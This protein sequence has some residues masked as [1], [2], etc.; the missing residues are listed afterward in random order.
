MQIDIVGGGL[1]GLSTAISLKNLHKTIEVN[2]FEK[3]EKIGY[4]P[5]GR[6]CGE[7]YTYN[8]EWKYW[9]PVGKSYYND[10]YNFQIILSNKSY[11]LKRKPG[12]SY[13]L[14]RQEF[15]LQN[16]KKAKELGVNFFTNQKIKSID[17]LDGDYIIDA[18]GCPSI[19]KR[20]LKI[21]HQILGRSY[22][23]TLENSNCFVG[24][25]VKIFVKNSTG[26][27]WI[28]PRDSKKKEVNIGFGILFGNT[29]L[30]LKECL[31]RFKIENDIKGEVN[32]V[33][34]G[35]IP[36]GIQRPLKYNNILFVGDAGV[37]TF[38]LTAEGIYRALLSGEI[39]AR[40]I[41]NNQPQKYPYEIHRKFI[42]WDIVGKSI[43]RSGNILSYIGPEASNLLYQKFLDFI[44]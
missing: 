9:K 39:A 37:G 4:N 24:D 43:I 18:S 23:Q 38:P 26:Y 21:K 31:N 29:N 30:K 27:Y 33:T 12:T 3:H 1:S 6:R 7:A 35:V 17:E 22:Q 41:V 44:Y 5:D 25:T 19:I 15:L 16:C 10:I 28:F 13:V 2:V 34:G 14:N 20:D 36:L 40:C 42:K 32:H 8:K 11:T